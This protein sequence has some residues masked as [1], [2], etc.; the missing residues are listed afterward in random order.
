MNI[1]KLSTSGEKSATSMLTAFRVLR[2]LRIFKL[3][4]RSESLTTLINAIK[5]TILDVSSFYMLLFL[6]VFVF[7]LVG[8][9][10]FAYRIKVNN[11]DDY[12]PV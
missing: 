1:E 4:L 8:M 10:F 6:Y 3:A 7:A 2:I 12:V 5:E 11:L 9:E